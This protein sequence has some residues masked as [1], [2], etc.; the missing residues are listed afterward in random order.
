MSFKDKPITETIMMLFT[1]TVQSKCSVS[2]QFTVMHCNHADSNDP[3]TV[4]GNDSHYNVVILEPLFKEVNHCGVTVHFLDL[5]A[6]PRA[7]AVKNYRGTDIAN[8]G[9]DMYQFLKEGTVEE[10]VPA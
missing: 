10:A 1:N 8:I 6:R 3:A 4:I 7:I 5:N 9:S 2:H